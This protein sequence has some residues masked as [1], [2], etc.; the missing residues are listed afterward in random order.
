MNYIKTITNL[1]IH[2]ILSK[3]KAN[4][5]SFFLLMVTILVFISSNSSVFIENY[6]LP[7]FYNNYAQMLRYFTKKLP[8]SIGDCVYIF[9]VLY[10]VYLLLAYLYRCIVLKKFYI[11]WKK[12]VAILLA[13]YIVFNV[14][15]GLNY[16]RKGI[17]NQLKI[18][19]QEY[20]LVEL[21]NLI[22]E[23]IDTINSCKNL[24]SDT[25][26]PNISFDNCQLEAINCYRKIATEYPF[27]SYK[28][29]SIKQSLYSK[30][31]NHLGFIGYYNPFTGEAQIRNDMPSILFPFTICHEV[32]HQIGYASEEEANF[33]SYLVCNKSDNIVFKYSV[34]LEMLDYLLHNLLLKHLQLKD[35]EGYSSRMY[36]IKDCINSWVLK[37]R[38]QIRQFFANNKS[39]LKP[40][41]NS[42]YDSYLKLNSQQK[43]IDSY[44][45]VIGLI[46]AYKKLLKMKPVP[47]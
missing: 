25:N 46:I 47:M 14:S 1:T 23:T 33:V 39:A 41:S 18:S 24:L 43:G 28:N 17:A 45:E 2:N 13:I 35:V 32:A 40:I 34:S 27:L 26:L 10:I 37:D 38:Q 29:A 11:N 21:N 15:W 4:K 3:I 7:F 12:S 16:N 6:Y 42:V 19:K 31:G 22:D 5:K 30:L 44:N 20:S 9:V 8:F 36:Q